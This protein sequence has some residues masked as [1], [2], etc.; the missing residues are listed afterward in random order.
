[1]CL[2]PSEGTLVLIGT[3]LDLGPHPAGDVGRGGLGR[4]LGLALCSRTLKHQVP[5][6]PA[7][8]ESHL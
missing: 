4:P 7:V 3:G 1:M 8:L 6:G 2:H 5:P